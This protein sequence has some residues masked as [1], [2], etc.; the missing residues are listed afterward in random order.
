VS[1]EAK[2]AILFIDDEANFLQALKRSFATE[3]LSC[4]FCDNFSCALEVLERQRIDLV[5]CDEL[6]PGKSG[7]E[8]LGHVREVYPSV[9]RIL[10]TGGSSMG[11]AVASVNH[12]Q[13]Y[14]Y[15]LKPIPHERLI[16]AIHEALDHK[17]LADQCRKALRALK[18]QNLLIKRLADRHPELVAQAAA[19]LSAQDDA[20]HER[21]QLEQAITLALRDVGDGVAKA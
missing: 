6:M 13:V 3:P 4:S 19:S 5:V 10:L 15:L 9:M 18:R 7:W 20:P 12:G 21:R 17:S 16:E 14:R 1:T 11:S 8:F 2:P